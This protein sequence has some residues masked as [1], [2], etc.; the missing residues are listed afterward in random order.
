MDKTAFRIYRTTVYLCLS[1]YSR[2]TRRSHVLIVS[3]VLY[4]L[5]C[6]TFPHYIFVRKSSVTG[7]EYPKF[8]K[9]DIIKEEVKVKLPFEHAGQSLKQEFPHY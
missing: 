1:D 3:T 4:V 2:K 5:L 6:N 8:S 7:N 9:T